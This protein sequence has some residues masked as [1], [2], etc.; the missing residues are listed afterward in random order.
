MSDWAAQTAREQRAAEA[1]VSFVYDAGHG[2]LCVDSTACPEVKNFASKYSYVSQWQVFLEED[3]D[4][5]KFIEAL[6]IGYALKNIDNV[7]LDD[8]Q[9]ARLRGM[10][11]GE[12]ELCLSCEGKGYDGRGEDCGNCEGYGVI[13]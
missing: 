4:A 8:E 6:G 11:R 10:R 12:A 5:P 2:W 3:E 1:L 7:E 9:A 13:A